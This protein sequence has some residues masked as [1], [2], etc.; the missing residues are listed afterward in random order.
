VS[1]LLANDVLRSGRPWLHS[2]LNAVQARGEEGVGVVGGEHIDRVALLAPAQH[3]AASRFC[4]LVSCHQDWH[5]WTDGVQCTQPDWASS[6]LPPVRYQVVV[7]HHI[8]ALH[9]LQGWPGSI[10]SPVD[11]HGCHNIR[12]FCWLQ[13]HC[14]EWVCGQGSSTLCM[15]DQPGCCSPPTLQPQCPNKPGRPVQQDKLV[16]V[17]PVSACSLKLSEYISHF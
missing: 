6:S 1:C 12:P 16:T 5:G 9:A 7:R 14:T 2:M 3:E 15:T 11:R 4:C 8:T 13:G 17:M 10:R